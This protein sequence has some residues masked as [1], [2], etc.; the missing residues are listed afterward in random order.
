MKL[1]AKGVCVTPGTVVG[2]SRII[3]SAE[4]LDKITNGDVIVLPRS[5]PQF[6]LGLYKASAVIC[7]MGGVLSHLCIVSMEMGI[8]CITQTQ[9]ARKLIPDDTWV[10]VDAVSGEISMYTD[11]AEA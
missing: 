4:D 7:E 1:L 3:N 6:A 9:D 2:R 8:P 11:E 5:D 10:Y